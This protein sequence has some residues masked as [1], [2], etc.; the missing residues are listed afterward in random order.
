[1]TDS[2]RFGMIWLQRLLLV[3]GAVACMLYFSAHALSNALMLLMDRKNF[4]P[5]QSS[6]WTFEPYEINQGSSSYWLYGEDG[7]NYYFF[8]YTPEDSYRLI[9]KDNRCAGFDKRDVR[10]WCSD[11][12]GEVRR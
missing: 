5:A 7:D 12:A 8:A 6:I 9:A 11:H 1:M 4:I 3:V 2:G 10:T